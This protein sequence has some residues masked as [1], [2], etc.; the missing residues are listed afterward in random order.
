M[1]EFQMIFSIQN[2][3]QTEGEKLTAPN[4]YLRTFVNKNFIPFNI[5]PAIW[6]KHNSISHSMTSMNPQLLTYGSISSHQRETKRTRMKYKPPRSYWY[7]SAVLCLQHIWSCLS[8]TYQALQPDVKP[9]KTQTLIG[10]KINGPPR[11]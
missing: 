11:N 9:G 7:H 2:H 5:N 3:F 10:L 6:K 4:L 1:E 8:L